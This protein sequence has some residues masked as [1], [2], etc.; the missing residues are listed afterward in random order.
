MI[1]QYQGLAGKRF[2]EI[3][4]VEQEP[5]ILILT[6]HYL[7]VNTFFYNIFLNSV[8]LTCEIQKFVK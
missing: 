4:H 2:L 7:A 3:R 8:V 1:F 6:M 5:D